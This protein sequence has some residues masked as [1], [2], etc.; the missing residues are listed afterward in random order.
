[1][2]QK[3]KKFMAIHKTLY[4]RDD[5]NRRYVSRKGGIVHTSIEYYV[6]ASIQGIKDNKETINYIISEC[7]QS[8]KL[9][10]TGWG[11]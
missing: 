7:R 1:M 3:A 8:M 6:D 9:E 4:P 2:D 10:M 11:R 5:I